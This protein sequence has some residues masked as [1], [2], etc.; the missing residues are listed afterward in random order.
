MQI[1][2]EKFNDL[3]EHQTMAHLQTFGLL[4]L[5]ICDAWSQRFCR[6]LRCLQLTWSLYNW[7][8]P[9]TRK[10]QSRKT[11]SYRP[12]IAFW[13]QIPC[14]TEIGWNEK[15]HQNSRANT[16]LMDATQWA[17]ASTC[18]NRTNEAIWHAHLI[19]HLNLLTTAFVYRNTEIVLWWNR[20]SS[21]TGGML[22]L[23]NKYQHHWIRFLDNSETL[24]YVLM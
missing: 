13:S 7:M 19:Y 23:P 9:T 3:P 20:D 24:R 1:N 12:K 6:F 11:L 5:T 14:R 2:P 8:W 17:K 21:S 4:A 18:C 22:W 16:E 10:P 15:Q